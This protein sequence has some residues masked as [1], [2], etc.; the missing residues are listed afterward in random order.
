LRR[1]PRCAGGRPHQSTV[2]ARTMWRV[3]LA[4]C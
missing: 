3:G 2:S 4:Y 1:R